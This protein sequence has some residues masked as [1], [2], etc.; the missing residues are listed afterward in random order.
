MDDIFFEYLVKDT[1]TLDRI[2]R[3]LTERIESLSRS[4]IKKLIDEG[5]VTINQE[6]VKASYKVKIDDLIEINEVDLSETTVV[7]VKMNLDIVYEDDDVLVINKPSGMVVHP[8]PGHYQDTLVNGLL[9]H[10][11]SLSDINGDMR[12]GIVHR[13]DKDTSGLLMV[14]KNNLAHDILAKELQTKKTKR[15][16]IALVE[17]VIN[18]KRG[19]I[20]APIGRDKKNRLKMAVTSD[21]KAAVTNFEVIETFSDS[22]LIKCILETGRTHQIRVHMQYINHPLVND[23][24][25]GKAEVNDFGQFL[26]AQVLGFT[27]PKT[28]QWLEF[29]CDLPKE[30]HDLVENKRIKTL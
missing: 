20:N 29:S 4:T 15:E 27:H 3:F 1:D 23:F 25:Y 8:A 17:G 7:P 5:Q 26:H 9:W 22:S 14:A 10:I 11:K 30:F 18:N 16:Y 19:R 24:V 28:K 21:G 13:I 2:D 6:P 12:P